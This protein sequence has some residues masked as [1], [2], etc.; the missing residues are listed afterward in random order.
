MTTANKYNR[1]DTPM[2]H[3]FIGRQ[4]ELEILDQELLGPTS[5]IV[6]ITG[7]AGIGKTSLAMVF[8]ELN[9]KAFPAGTFCLQATPYESLLSSVNR[10]ANPNSSPYLLIINDLETRPQDLLR[11][12]LNALQRNHPKAQILLTSRYQHNFNNIDRQLE[13]GGFS[14][15]EFHK[16]LEKKLLAYSGSSQLVNELY[17]SLKG[18]PLATN[19]VADLLQKGDLTPRQLLEKLVEFT[20]PGFVDPTGVVIPN[21]E[22]EQKKI[23]TDVISVSDDLLKELHKNPKIIYDLS[24]RGFEVLVADLLG[25]LN[26]EVTLTPASKDGGKDIYAAKKDHLGTFL[27][28]VECKKYAPDRPVGVG[29]IRQLSGVVN[30]EQATAGILATT[31][32]F[33]KGAEEFQ[34]TLSYQISLKDYIGIQTW[35]DAVVKK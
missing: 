4:S 11:E 23:I 19:I 18:H 2:T 32:F 27:Y 7:S 28:I 17:A 1:Y 30:A 26:Y 6:S 10:D 8:A 25:R 29:I 24:P 9:K 13:I 16:F 3:G 31:S 20:W 15:N 21:T 12:E 14:E 35:L 5:K 33:T 22:K 34:R